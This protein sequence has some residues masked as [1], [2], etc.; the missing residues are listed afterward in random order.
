MSPFEE[1]PTESISDM[2]S[3]GIVYNRSQ[4][5]SDK[6][7]DQPNKKEEPIPE[8]PIDPNKKDPEQIEPNIGDPPIKEPKVDKDE[9]EGI[10]EN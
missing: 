10:Y 8:M 1:R 6:M 7:A 2:M 5:I 4:N 3:K 9:D